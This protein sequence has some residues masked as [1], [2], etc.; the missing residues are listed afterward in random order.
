MD[1]SGDS[2]TAM[3][4][5]AVLLSLCL[6]SYYYWDNPKQLLRYGFFLFL[7]FAF[8]VAVR[9]IWFRMSGPLKASFANRK[10]ESGRYCYVEVCPK[11]WIFLVLLIKKV[12]YDVHVSRGDHIYM[13]T[14]CIDTHDRD[15][16]LIGAI[17]GLRSLD[18]R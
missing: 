17:C 13:Y 4:S 1:R 6:I 14:C 11:P 9:H 8:L 15:Q 10:E 3:S 2:L 18:H 5:L 12:Y 16:N 7:V